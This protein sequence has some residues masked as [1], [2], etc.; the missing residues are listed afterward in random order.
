M[1]ALNIASNREGDTMGIQAGVGVSVLRNPIKA[2]EEAL[3]KASAQ[4]GCNPDLVVVFCASEYPYQTIL[5]EIKTRFP[6]TP[7][8]GCSAAGIISN[9]VS[10]EGPFGIEIALLASDTI[11]FHATARSGLKINSYDAGKEL[12]TFFSGFDASPHSGIMILP[13]G[14]TVNFDRLFQGLGQTYQPEGFVPFFGGLASENWQ[15]VQTHQFYNNA[16][17]TDSVVAVLIT[18]DTDIVFGVNH[19]CNP[20]GREMKITKAAGNI[21]EEIDNRPALDA[22][23]DYF[24]IADDDAWNKATNNLTIALAAEGAAQELDNYVIRYMPARDVKN[25]TFSIGTEVSEG[26]SIWLARRDYDKVEE[27][28]NRLVDVMGRQTGKRKLDCVFQFDCAGRGNVIFKEEEKL[29]LLS[30]LHCGIDPRIPW[31]GFHCFGE[32]GPIGIE[33]HFH[34]YT[35]V[36]AGFIGEKID[37]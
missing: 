12:G 6:A 25:R 33:N 8:V 35:V 20:V 27:G 9:E 34:N 31:I 32:I 2:V 36:L 28:V 23:K 13:D 16:V 5:D 3:E 24:D 15:F 18:G 7:L 26:T 30:K 29:A 1:L 14:L 19:G 21:I 4:I 11:Q 37:T 22:M 10:I 17:L